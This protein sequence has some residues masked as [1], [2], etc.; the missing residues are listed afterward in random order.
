M[1]IYEV[2]KKTFMHRWACQEGECNGEMICVGP[3]K[4][5]GET[6]HRCDVCRNE[7]FTYDGTSYPHKIYRHVVNRILNIDP[8]TGEIL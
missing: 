1:K 3:H 7:L 4:L 8:K 2:E 6:L 5:T